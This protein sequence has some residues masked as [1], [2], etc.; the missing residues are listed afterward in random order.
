MCLQGQLLQTPSPE[1]RLLR[2]EMRRQVDDVRA[3]TKQASVGPHFL[4]LPQAKAIYAKY[5]RDY[6]CRG[7]HVCSLRVTSDSLCN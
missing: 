5:L 7:T 1:L 3:D 2:D 4:C 6:L